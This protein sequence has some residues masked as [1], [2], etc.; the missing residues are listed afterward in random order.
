[1][2]ILADVIKYNTYQKCKRYLFSY[3]RDN[4]SEQNVFETK[5]CVQNNLFHVCN[6]TFHISLFDKHLQ[7]LS[8]L[9][10][11]VRGVFTLFQ[12]KRQNKFKSFF[13]LSCHFLSLESPQAFFIT[14]FFSQNKT[15][16]NEKRC[17]SSFEDSKLCQKQLQLPFS[18]PS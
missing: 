11:A 12:F 17:K 13:C 4:L 7:C 5:N 9:L 3:K 2:S 16:H 14:D 10:N 1:M 8:F 15:L 6:S 18:L